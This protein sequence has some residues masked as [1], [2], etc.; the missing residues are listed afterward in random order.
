MPE[1]VGILR[2]CI[3]DDD[4]LLV[5]S[6]LKGANCFIKCSLC[7]TEEILLVCFQFLVAGPLMSRQLVYCSCKLI[8]DFNS[9]WIELDDD[10]GEFL[11]L[12]SI[13]LSEVCE[14]FTKLVIAVDLEIVLQG[15]EI[16]LPLV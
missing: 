13:S 1:V 2:I 5:E 9:N 15:V 11:L 7:L 8:Y 12:L 16:G 10:A 6:I 14:T 4:V 3:V